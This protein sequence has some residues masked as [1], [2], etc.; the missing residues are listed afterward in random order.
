MLEDFPPIA[1]SDITV[2]YLPLRKGERPSKQTIGNIETGKLQFG[3]VLECSFE[4]EILHW[5]KAAIDAPTQHPG[6]REHLSHYRNL[7]RY[8]IGKD[9]Q[10]KTRSE[11]INA[12]RIGEKACNYQD[13]LALRDNVV[14]LID[15]YQVLELVDNL[16]S[17]QKK[18]NKGG[19]T[20]RFYCNDDVNV[21]FWNKP[22]EM[23]TETDDAFEALCRK[24][25][26][27]IGKPVLSE[28]RVVTV[29]VFHAWIEEGKLC[30]GI[31][32]RCLTT[33]KDSGYQEIVSTTI[34]FVELSDG[35]RVDK[36]EDGVMFHW[37]NLDRF[38]IGSGRNLFDK[39]A[40]DIRSY[41]GSIAEKAQEAKP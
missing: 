23:L 15:A 41:Y 14:Q 25:V 20:F 21:G 13:F 9:M 37:M 31:G 18:L 29:V 11:I 22:L 2:I 33:E 8:R 1:L 16:V 12:I 26:I 5:L 10:M 3:R 17:L 24:E 7:I 30:T 4:S 35:K 40:A 28:G 39:Y 34:P 32:D 19:K 38:E 6:M 36:N 27:M